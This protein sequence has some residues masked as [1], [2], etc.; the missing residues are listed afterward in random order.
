MFS[1]SRD[2]TVVQTVRCK[3]LNRLGIQCNKMSQD[4]AN[5][6]SFHAKQIYGLEVKPSLIESAGKGLFTTRQFEKNEII[7]EYCGEVLH[8][9]QL[10]ER[11]PGDTLGMYVL[12]L[13]DDWY[14]DARSTQS[15]VARYC[16]ASDWGNSTNSSKS[17]NAMFY[18]DKPNK[19]VY[20]MAT[21]TILPG[22]EIL[23]C[24]GKSYY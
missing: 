2:Q 20:L 19:K 24:Y 23:C 14:V 18:Q 22:Q 6:C 11:Y 13:Y 10:E 9:D 1:S 12:H 15:C 8:R 5:Y 7:S 17:C 4:I 21:K 3:A 16:N